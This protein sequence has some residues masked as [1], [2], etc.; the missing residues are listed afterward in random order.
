MDQ[1]ITNEL[2]PA[3]PAI[4]MMAICDLADRIFRVTFRRSASVSR[5]ESV[6]MGRPD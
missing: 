4:T 3:S 5:S 2:S 6:T 1:T